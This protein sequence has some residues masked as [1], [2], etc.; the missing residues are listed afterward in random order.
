MLEDPNSN[1]IFPKRTMLTYWLLSPV[2][3]LQKHCPGYNGLVHVVCRR[4]LEKDEDS[5]E[6][7]SVVCPWCDP[8]KTIAATGVTAAY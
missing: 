8:Q 4:V 3:E 1:D 2:H 5:F 6:A 7:D